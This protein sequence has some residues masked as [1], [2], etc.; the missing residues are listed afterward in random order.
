[1]ETS[2][3]KELNI[4]YL[5]WCGLGNCFFLGM[6]SFVKDNYLAWLVCVLVLG[7]TGD[8]FD[9]SFLILY[10]LVIHMHA[11]LA[12]DYNITHNLVYRSIRVLKRFSYYQH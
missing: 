12:C 4:L 9:Q 2:G 11:T 5:V 1:M 10:G 7:I 3:L 6:G 8:L